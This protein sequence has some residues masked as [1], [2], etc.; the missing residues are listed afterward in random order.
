MYGLFADLLHTW[1]DMVDRDKPI[2]AEEI[3]RAFLIALALL[4]ANPVYQ[5]VQGFAAPFWICVVQAYEAANAMEREG[6]GHGLEISHSL[7]YA[8]GH[9]IAYAMAATAG[10]EASARYAPEMW[11]CVIAE[12]FEPYRMEHQK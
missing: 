6:E 7:R 3:N 4:P 8:A 2:S 9:I 5:R 10:Y 12:R 1:D 11:R